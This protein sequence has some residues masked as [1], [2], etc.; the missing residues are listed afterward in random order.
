MILIFI[1]Y[2][3]WICEGFI[4]HRVIVISCNVL[5]FVRNLT[6]QSR[7]EAQNSELELIKSRKINRFSIFPHY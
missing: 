6:E 4:Y 5:V 1:C 7:L 2:F 3:Y